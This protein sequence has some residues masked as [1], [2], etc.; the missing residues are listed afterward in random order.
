ME[1]T[2]VQPT[3]TSILST[4]KEKGQFSGSL[5]R[6]RISCW[7]RTEFMWCSNFPWA[8]TQ[9]WWRH[10]ASQ[11]TEG[12]L[13]GSS[14]RL[15]GRQKESEFW[16]SGRKSR[17]RGREDKPSVTNRSS[18]R[19]LHIVLENLGRLKVWVLSLPS[20]PPSSSS[21]SFSFAA[22][23]IKPSVSHEA[24]THSVTEL[25]PQYHKLGFSSSWRVLEECLEW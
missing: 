11:I 9:R 23:R 10:S 3:P 4:R 7:R 20:L 19:S 12:Y 2:Q 15:Q 21:P 17:I 1:D 18:A 25:Y 16:L 5:L 14:L 22:I 8:L 6:T 24:D 13:L